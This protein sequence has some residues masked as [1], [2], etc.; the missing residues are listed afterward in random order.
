MPELLT[1]GRQDCG[2]VA[3]LTSEWWPASV[4]NGGRLHVGIP[5]RIEPK[6]AL[7]AEELAMILAELFRASGRYRTSISPVMP[8]MMA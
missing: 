4:R 6:S 7:T 2:G 8:K 1:R 3:G 5:G